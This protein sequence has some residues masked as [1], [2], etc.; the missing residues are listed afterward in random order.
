MLIMYEFLSTVAHTRLYKMRDA[1]CEMRYVT[2]VYNRYE[3]P[4]TLV[5]RCLGTRAVLQTFDDEAS[6]VTCDTPY[7]MCKL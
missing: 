3:F 5:H 7:A 4:S 1:R 6:Y 2:C